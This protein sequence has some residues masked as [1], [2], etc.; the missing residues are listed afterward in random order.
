MHRS[1]QDESV[2]TQPVTMVRDVDNNGIINESGFLLKQSRCVRYYDQSMRL[3]RRCSRLSLAIAHLIA[4]QY[5]C[6]IYEFL[7]LSYH[8]LAPRLTRSHATTVDLQ[9][10][11]CDVLGDL[12]HLDHAIETMVL[13]HQ[14][15]DV[16]RGKLI[17]VQKRFIVASMFEPFNCAV[18][19]PC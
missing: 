2:V 6:K 3:V 1:F 18:C 11:V 4:P 10:S 5:D 12:P 7:H 13:V 16:G 19:C 8:Q 9:R 14:M 15:G 17:H